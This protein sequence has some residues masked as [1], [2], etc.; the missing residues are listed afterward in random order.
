MTAPV[1]SRLVL[2]T[3]RSIPLA[4]VNS[5]AVSIHINGT[6]PGLDISDSANPEFDVADFK[7]ELDK[8]RQ[9]Q[10]LRIKSELK[11]ESLGIKKIRLK[12]KRA[13]TSARTLTQTGLFGKIMSLRDVADQVSALRQNGL[14][15]TILK[16]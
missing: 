4:A 9:Q 12:L 16:I 7:A 5:A 2:E 6:R 15:M 1:P 13:T 14:R 8:I 11:L 3:G 10:A